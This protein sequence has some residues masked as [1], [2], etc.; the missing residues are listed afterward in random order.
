M[1]PYTD[2]PWTEVLDYVQTAEKLGFE[3]VF[4][5]EAYSYDSVSIMG[6]LAVKT[7]RIK[8]G[9]GIFNVFSR[10]AAL[11][12]QS[13]GALDMLSNGRFIL[14]LGTSGPQ[15]VQGFHGVPFEKPLPRTR[16]Y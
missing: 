3:A 5:A 4:V 10:S 15:V 8:I 1:L 13:A 6:A 11:I 16:E 14:G 9:S 2:L 12:A 7:D